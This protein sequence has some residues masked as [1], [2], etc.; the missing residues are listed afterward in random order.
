MKKLLSFIFGIL[1]GLV[2]IVFTL[3]L[4][5]C[6]LASSGEIPDTFLTEG[7]IL[8]VMIISFVVVCALN[9]YFDQ[10]EG[11]ASEKK[12]IGRWGK[13]TLFLA[14][15]CAFLYGCMEFDIRANNDPLNEQKNQMY[16]LLLIGCVLCGAIYYIQNY[17]KLLTRK[18]RINYL[19]HQNEKYKNRRYTFI[20]KDIQET[21]KNVVLKGFVLGNMHVLDEVYV[22]SMTQEFFTTRIISITENSKNVRK[23]KDNDI[24]ITLKKNEE[25]KN[26]KV[27]NVL[28]DILGFVSEGKENNVENPYIRGLITGYNELRKEKEFTTVLF[29]LIANAKFLVA[30]KSTTKRDADM[31]DPLTDNTQVSFLSVST[32]EDSS[33]FI[34]PAFTDWDALKCWSTM[35]QEK[36]AV[37][38]V[39]EYKEVEGIMEKGFGGIVINPFGPQPF[40]LPKELAVSLIDMVYTD[41]KGEDRH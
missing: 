18:T 24:E 12:L 15:I 14:M 17:R 28:T 10:S 23:A 34:L 22:Y 5:V 39:M 25:T 29:W 13:N 21:D 3:M 35:M 6:L 31:M 40:F 36:D 16:L 27:G 32:N 9:R 38:L 2:F 26:I 37:T 33:L 7:I 1:F 8:V 41:E 20:V 11:Y 4:E 30:G 19:I